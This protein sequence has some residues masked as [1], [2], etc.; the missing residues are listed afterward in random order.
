MHHY[1]EDGVE[2]HVGKTLFTI[3]LT[4]HDSGAPVL[5]TGPIRG[6][7]ESSAQAMNQAKAEELGREIAH[8]LRRVLR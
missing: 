6:I 3:V 4:N 7:F 8:V 2:A 1:G 5:V